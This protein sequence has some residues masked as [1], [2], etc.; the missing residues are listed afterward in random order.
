[1]EQRTIGMLPISVGTS[2]A[3]ESMIATPIK[4]IDSLMINVGTI[5]RNAYQ[6]YETKVRSSLTADQL[7]QDVLQDLGGIYEVLNRLSKDKTP[8]MVAYYCSY[9]GLAKRFTLA[10]I[11]KPETKIQL[12][13]ASLEDQVLKRL[14][15]Q[16]R[17]HIRICDHTMPNGIR[18][19]YVLTH[20]IVDLVVPSGYGDITLIESHTAALKER[21]EW[22]TKLTGGSKFERIPFNPLTLQV[23]GDNSTNFKANDFKYKVAIHELAEKY[24]WTPMT[25][26]E[27]VKLGIASVQDA[28]LR[29]N[30]SQMLNA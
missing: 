4:K 29:A 15:S 9:A 20:H 8:N 1:M 24:E 17:G 18:N 25:S 12:H 13:Y 2:L 5:F 14:L 26:D 23:F 3:F 16:L 21:G 10:K 22:Q 7:Y 30:L 28:D 11:W 27:R 6:A 19:T